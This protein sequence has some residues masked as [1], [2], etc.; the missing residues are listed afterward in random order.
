MNIN[1]KFIEAVFENKLDEAKKYVEQGAD[2]N[3]TYEDGRVALTYAV[4]ARNYEMVKYLVEQGANPNVDPEL[5]WIVE[6]NRDI[7][8]ETTLEDG[9]TVVDDSCQKIA[10]YL[11]DKFDNENIIIQ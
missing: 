3:Y 6:N 9:T 8:I 5:Q 4:M 10:E 7:K 1:E 2:V 11:E